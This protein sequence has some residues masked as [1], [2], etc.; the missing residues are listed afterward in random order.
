MYLGYQGRFGAICNRRHN[1]KYV[2]WQDFIGLYNIKQMWILIM[3]HVQNISACICLK[4]INNVIV[5]SGLGLLQVSFC[6]IIL[7]E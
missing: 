7:S 3:H 1:I 2:W 4:V 6:S 5:L